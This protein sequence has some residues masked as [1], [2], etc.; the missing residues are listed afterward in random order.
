MDVTSWI[1][2]CTPVDLFCPGRPMLVVQH[3]Y[4]MAAG[5]PTVEVDANAPHAPDVRR[6]FIPFRRLTAPVRRA[7]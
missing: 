6:V 5:R 1:G 2:T 7:K 3:A 4:D